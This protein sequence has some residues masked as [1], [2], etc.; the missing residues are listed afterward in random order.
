MG[1]EL[2]WI[3]PKSLG[4]VK[5]MPQILLPHSGQASFVLFVLAAGRSQLA[6]FRVEA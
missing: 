4:C 3:L 5:L 6:S 2:H 1:D